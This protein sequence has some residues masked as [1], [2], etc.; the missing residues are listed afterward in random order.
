M[1]LVIALTVIWGTIFVAWIVSWFH[2]RENLRYVAADRD[3]LVRYARSLIEVY[4]PSERKEVLYR[5]L[6]N[7]GH[8]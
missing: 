1:P 8:P 7:R 2:E 4:A 5:D 3:R 6:E